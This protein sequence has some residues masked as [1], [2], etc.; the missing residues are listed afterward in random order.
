MGAKHEEGSGGFQTGVPS[1]GQLADSRTVVFLSPLGC[2]VHRL[3][4]SSRQAQ[5]PLP[6]GWTGRSAH[7][8][9]R[10]LQSGDSR[11]TGVLSGGT[12][13]CALVT[14]LLSVSS[15]GLVGVRRDP[16]VR[17]YNCPCYPSILGRTTFPSPAHKDV[18]ILIP[19]SCAC[20]FTW[21]EELWEHD[22]VT[23][24]AMGE[25]PRR[26]CVEELRNRKREA[27]D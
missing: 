2:V 19:K 17:S 27:G 14:L 5:L 24:L 23:D 12:Q 11:P 21:E 25:C 20:K 4:A 13:H 9:V 1:L 10:K 8:P 3:E 26:R 7:T 6:M 16:E 18:H 22:K 15:G